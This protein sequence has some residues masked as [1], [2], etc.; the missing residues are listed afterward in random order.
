VELYHMKEASFNKLVYLLAPHLLVDHVKSKNSSAGV[1]PI[2]KSVIVA[3]GLRWLG[4]E[5]YK[6]IADIFHISRASARRSVRRFINAVIANL[7]N[8]SLPT[9][10]EELELLAT[11]WRSKSTADGCYHG[12]VFALDGYLSFRTQPSK[13]ECNNTADYFSGH[14]RV[15]AINVQAAVD[16]Q[17]RFRYVSVAA[18]GK[19]NDGRAFLTECPRLRQ[20]LQQLSEKYF[21]CADNAYPIS[22]NLLVPFKGAEADVLYHAAYNFYLSQLRIRVEMAFGRMTTK[23]R[24][25][26]NKLTCTLINHG[27]VIQDITRLHNFIIDNDKPYWVPFVWMPM[28]RLTPPSCNVSVLNHCL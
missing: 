19:T 12:L 27:K 18:P 28:V 2:N 8:I 24:I 22:N 10:D 21:I 13:A 1:S 3:A 15:P 4:G 14:K 17:L 23:F 6:S 26:R 20:W 25:L 7:N 11:G 9:S 16:H 5:L